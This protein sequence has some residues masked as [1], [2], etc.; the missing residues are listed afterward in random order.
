MPRPSEAIAMSS[1]QVEGK[2]TKVPIRR[3]LGGRIDGLPAQRTDGA[4]AG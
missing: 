1:P 2:I 3:G 4:I